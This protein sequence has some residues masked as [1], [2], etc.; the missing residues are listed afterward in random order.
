MRA[1]L[2]ISGRTLPEVPATHRAVFQ[3]VHFV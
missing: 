1:P 2:L 3:L